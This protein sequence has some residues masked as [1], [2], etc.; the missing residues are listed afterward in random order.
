MELIS[1]QLATAKN[2]L[3]SSAN[4]IN[5]AYAKRIID[6]CLNKYEP[7]TDESI[8]KI[9]SKVQREFG[10]SIKI[11]TKLELK[12]TK[13]QNQL[14]KVLQEDVYISSVEAPK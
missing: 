4:Y 8:R 3:D 12:F 10:K 13:S 7:L 6:W 5:R 11:Y 9:I 1:E 14:K 2:K